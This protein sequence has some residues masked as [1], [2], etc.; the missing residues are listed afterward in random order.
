MLRAV[1]CSGQ[2]RHRIWFTATL[3]SG[4]GCRATGGNM[5]RH[6]TTL[7]SHDASQTHGGPATP[8]LCLWL[9]A[10]LHADDEGA[11]AH[12]DK[13]VPSPQAPPPARTS[14]KWAVVCLRTTTA[15]LFAAP[16]AWAVP[17]DCSSP[18]F[19]R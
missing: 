14:D 9:W 13:S 18:A 5:G 1:I 17:S 16:R 11:K 6:R 3:M 7:H 4:S 10:G 19:L 12:W 8:A 15:P 2:F